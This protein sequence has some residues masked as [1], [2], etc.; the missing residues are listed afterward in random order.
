MVDVQVVVK[1][2]NRLGFEAGQEAERERVL[3][4]LRAKVSTHSGCRGLVDSCVSCIGYRQVIE[5]VEK[6]ADA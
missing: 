2:A 6:G 4:F 3:T 1:L 5:Y